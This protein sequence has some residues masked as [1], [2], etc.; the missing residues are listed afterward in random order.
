MHSCGLQNIPKK[1][2]GTAVSVEAF[3][4]THLYLGDSLVYPCIAWTII[5]TEHTTQG[6]K[7]I[8]E[9]GW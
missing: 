6:G 1:P 3:R 7:R 2:E 4:A 8:I 5:M 9:A